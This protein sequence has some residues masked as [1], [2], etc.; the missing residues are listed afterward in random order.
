M[1]P[2]KKKK[3]KKKNH[4][5]VFCELYENCIKKISW[6]YGYSYNKSDTETNLGS[7]ETTLAARGTTEGSGRSTLET[8]NY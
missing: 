6:D 7:G 4:Y 5:R 2:V 8:E 1:V 3:K